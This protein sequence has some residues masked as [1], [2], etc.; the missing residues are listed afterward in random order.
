MPEQTHSPDSVESKSQTELINQCTKNKLAEVEQVCGATGVHVSRRAFAAI[1]CA[2]AVGVSSLSG[3]VSAHGFEQEST[4]PQD[5]G[6]RGPVQ[7]EFQRDYDPPTFTPKWE[8]PQLNHQL[9]QDFILFAHSD[10]EMTKRLY[11]KD[12][13][14]LHA[15]IDWGKGDWECAMGGASHMGRHDIVEFLLSRGARMDI[16]CAAM[17]GLIDVV[18][19]MLTLEPALIDCRGPH[20][21]SL[22]FHALVGQERAKDVL[23]YLQSIKK[24]EL[25]EPA[26]L[27]RNKK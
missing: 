8:N 21:F 20:G 11:E 9:V 2:A 13:R 16:F 22:H 7:E 26:F 27:K 24:V 23:D 5:D 14:V 3:S 6:P 1:G 10:L 17:M 12:S 4:A 19:S 25:R 18:K 15:T